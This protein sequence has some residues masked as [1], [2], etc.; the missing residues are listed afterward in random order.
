M[1]NILGKLRDFPVDTYAIFV[2]GMACTYWPQ[3][4]ARCSV[5]L[6]T[7]KSKEIAA[8]LTSINI[9]PSLFHVAL[10]CLFNGRL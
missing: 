9:I 7:H 8:M 6:G 4:G 1:W 3:E 10:L 5:D 2:P